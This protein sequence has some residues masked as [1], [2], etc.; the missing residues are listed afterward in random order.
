MSRLLASSCHWQPWCWICS[1]I[2]PL[3]CTRN[4]NLNLPFLLIFIVILVY[5]FMLL[6]SI[7]VLFCGA[8]DDINLLPWWRNQMETLSALLA[9]CAGNSPVPDEFPSQRPLTRRFVVFF[10]LRLNK[11][12]SKQPWGWWFETLSRQLW[13]HRNAGCVWY[14]TAL[15]TFNMPHCF[16]DHKSC[17]CILNRID[18]AWWNW[19]L[20]NHRHFLV[21]SSSSAVTK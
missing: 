10:D 21:F 11:R 20:N 14:R 6:T 19:L 12:L 2:V 16:K 5:L 18:L 8:E 3:S 15:S 9:I 1:T 13:R 4:S 17:I 7:L